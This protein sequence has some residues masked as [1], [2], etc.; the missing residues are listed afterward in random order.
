VRDEPA[1]AVRAWSPH[2]STKQRQALERVWLVTLLA[3][4][5]LSVAQRQVWVQVLVVLDERRASRDLRQDHRAVT[6]YPW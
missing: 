1:D 2:H 3:E 6:A 4:V 5:R